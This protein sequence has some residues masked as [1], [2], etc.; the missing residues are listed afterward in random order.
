MELPNIN[1]FQN[2]ELKFKVGVTSGLYG[3]ARGEELATFI[4]KIGYTITRGTSVVELAADVPHE[5]D[6]S[7]G[8][9]IR[10]ISEKQGVDVSF[11]GSLTV[12]MCIPERIEWSVAQDHMQRS[13]KSAVYAGAKY[14]DFHSCLR[15]WLELFTYAGA[16]L[17][18]IMS[19]PEGNFIG[20]LFVNNPKLCDWFVKDTRYN[21][22]DVF[23]GAIL[24]PENA[25]VVTSDAQKEAL[26]EIIDDKRD[27]IKEKLKDPVRSALMQEKISRAAMEQR[28]LTQKEAEPTEAEINEGIDREIENI[29]TQDVFERKYNFLL[30]LNIK[31]QEIMKKMEDKRKEMVG[32]AVYEH[33]LE[34]GNDWYE[35]ERIGSTLEQAYYIIAHDLFLNQHPVWVELAKYYEQDLE[36]LKYN[37]DN[38]TADKEWLEQKIKTIEDEP[39]KEL[40]R[41]F[42]E[43][44]YGVVA[45]KFLEGHIV[46]LIDWMEKELPEIIK[47]EI[48]MMEP[49][50]H[51][52]EEESTKLKN[53]LD[54]LA[55]A[56]ENPDSRDP[57]H[58][59]R[60]LLWRPLQMHTGIKFIRE[61]LKRENYKHNDKVFV[62][63]DF[64]H[65]A[66]QGVDPLKELK[67]L[68]DLIPDYGKLIKTVHSGFPTPLHS[69]KPIEP[70]DREIIYRLL[71]ILK[72]AGLGSEVLTYIIFERGGFKDPFADSVGALKMMVNQLQKGTKPDE[73]PP[74]F[75]EI[76]ASTTKSRQEVI[77]FEHAF[78]PLKGM[79][80]VAEEEHT[81]LSTAAIKGGKSPEEW[82]KEE[83]R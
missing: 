18:I 67:E 76:P 25:R 28:R 8:K 49:E 45:I 19:D 75:Y 14:I 60:Y 83:L 6:Y 4:R 41:R 29:K 48:N 36:R 52:K 47:D 56:I 66:T 64:E 9:E 62:L 16:R 77:I 78:E 31:N 2:K 42:K 40:I 80:K 34:K 50:Q 17:N 1:P 55:I 65:L 70:G 43:F 22:L 5:V 3:I 58:G 35:K 21:F 23:S 27:L 37:F 53:I 24:K 12:A 59:G 30:S 69:H 26:D 44:Y 20:K 39:D 7:T 82:K 63:I 71:Y 79:L 61:R 73:L 32:K 46:K 13:I 38:P 15:E 54:N 81:L 57:S 33:L 10:Y 74:E 11:H 51:K 68:K 72:E